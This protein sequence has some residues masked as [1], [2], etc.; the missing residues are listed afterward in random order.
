MFILFLETQ[1]K[2]IVHDLISSYA[3]LA[4]IFFYLTSIQFTYIY[5]WIYT[6]PSDSRFFIVSKTYSKK[7]TSHTLS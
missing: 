4:S 5:F 6:T 7:E 2:Q 1:F 3:L